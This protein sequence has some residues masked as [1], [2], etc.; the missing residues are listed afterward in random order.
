MWK[1]NGVHIRIG[2]ITSSDRCSAFV[3]NFEVRL[4]DEQS[5]TLSAGLFSEDANLPQVLQ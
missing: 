1:W 2:I 5:V 4:V 3:E